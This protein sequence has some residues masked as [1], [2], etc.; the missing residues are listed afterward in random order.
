MAVVNNLVLWIRPRSRFVY[1]PYHRH[2]RSTACALMTL[3][4]LL[5]DTISAVGYLFFES[6]I[7]TEV[8]YCTMNNAGPDEAILFISSAV[9][10]LQRRKVVR[11][12]ATVLLDKGLFLKSRKT[13][14]TRRSVGPSSTL[15]AVN[16][17]CR[18]SLS[19]VWTVRFWFESLQS[20]TPYEQTLASR[21][22]LPM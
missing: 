2:I 11:W 9:V 21:L 15:K 8:T 7:S 6:K 5:T 19:I 4:E 13:L 16:L 3:Y 17:E 14:A 20:L 18:S 10:I 22:G 12:V 1:L